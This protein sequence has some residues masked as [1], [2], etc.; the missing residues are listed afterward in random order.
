MRVRFAVGLA[1]CL[2]AMV[3]V[4]GCGPGGGSG[5]ASPTVQPPVPP[6]GD[7]ISRPAESTLPSGGEGDR[8]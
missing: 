6:T 2:I 5:P 4:I 7:A 1:L 3:S 8:Q